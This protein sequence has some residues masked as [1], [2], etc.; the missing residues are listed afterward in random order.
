MIQLYSKEIERAKT[1]AQDYIDYCKKIDF[2]LEENGYS[3][4]WT[5]YRFYTHNVIEKY[6]RYWQTSKTPYEPKIYKSEPKAKNL[7]YENLVSDDKT[8]KSVYWDRG[9]INRFYRFIYENNCIISFLTQPS[10]TD[11]DFSLLTMNVYKEGN[12]QLTV[13]I[14][15]I[16]YELRIFD[17]VDSKLSSIRDFVYYED[18]I[19]ESR[20]DLRYLGDGTVENTYTPIQGWGRATVEK[21]ICPEPEL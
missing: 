6:K 5:K 18:R 15:R 19:Q 14:R 2:D 7:F 3:K 8:I 17:Y 20:F 16:D 10:K 12:P 13:N 9:R 11:E 1:V 21:W 4:V